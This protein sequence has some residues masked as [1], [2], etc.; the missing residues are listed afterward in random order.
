MAEILEDN[1]DD[2]YALSTIGVSIELLR[3]DDIL[4]TYIFRKLEIEKDT[5]P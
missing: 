3:I 1:I 5:D 4:N 2:C